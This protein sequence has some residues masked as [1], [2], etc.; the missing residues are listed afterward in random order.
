MNHTSNY[1]GNILV[2]DDTPANLRLLA[3]ILTQKGYKVRTVTNGELGTVSRNWHASRSDFAR[4]YDA[5]NGWL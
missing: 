4:Y 1:K 5:K 3:D 2:V